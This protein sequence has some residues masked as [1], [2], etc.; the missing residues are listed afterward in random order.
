MG[1]SFMD[2]FTLGCLKGF[3]LVGVLSL[4][5]F[6]VLGVNGYRLALHPPEPVLVPIDCKV[7]A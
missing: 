6:I 4:W 1:R 2:G 3:A 5:L 7:V